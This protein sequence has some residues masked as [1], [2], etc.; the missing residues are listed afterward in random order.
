MYYAHFLMCMRRSEE[1]LQQ[2]N[3]GLDLDP[4]KPLVLGLYGIVMN[5]NGEDESAIQYFEKALA[6]N[7]NDFFSSGN[8]KNTQ[9][10]EAY[11]TG[12]YE[13][14]FELWGEKVKGNWSEECRQSV[15][16]AFE[17]RGHIAGIEEMFKMHEKYGNKGALMTGGIKFERYMKLGEYTKAMD[18]LEE[19]FERQDMEM[20][21]LATNQYYPYLKDNPRYIALLKKMNLY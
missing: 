10:N 8:L 1:G 15:L 9:M 17:E 6:I 5:M 3:L 11:N 4:L 19:S 7:P 2:A 12:D 21:Y 16:N 18:Y 14:W 13:R 20:A